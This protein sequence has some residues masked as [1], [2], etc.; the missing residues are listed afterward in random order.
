M[1]VSHSSSDMPAGRLA[2]PVEARRTRFASFRLRAAALSPSD[3]FIEELV[4]LV[5]TLV[6]ETCSSLS[7]GAALEFMLLD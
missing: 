6:G 4:G 2:W 5:P 3:S 7:L 1:I